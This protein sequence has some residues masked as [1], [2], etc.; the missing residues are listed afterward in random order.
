MSGTYNAILP[1]IFPWRAIVSTENAEQIAA[2][3]IRSAT[4]STG[5]DI[6]A[7]GGSSFAI[8]R[9]SVGNHWPIIWVSNVSHRRLVHGNHFP[10]VAWVHVGRQDAYE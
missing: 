4:G 1:T 2:M 3:L 9:A 10:H 5:E 6:N 8:V 7:P